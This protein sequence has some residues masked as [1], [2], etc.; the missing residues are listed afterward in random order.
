[1]ITLLVVLTV[2]VICVQSYKMIR[3]AVTGKVPRDGS[4]D[5]AARRLGVRR[6]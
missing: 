3:I 4:S 5:Y 6:R 2:V 1:M